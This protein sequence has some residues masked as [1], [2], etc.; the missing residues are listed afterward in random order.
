MKSN[1]FFRAILLLIAA[2]VP[3]PITYAWSELGHRV[4]ARA[5]QEQLSSNAQIRLG[6]LLGKTTQ[7][8]DVATWADEIIQERPETESWHSI[9]IPPNASKV[10]L[11][12]DCPLGECITAKVRDCIGIVRLSVKPKSQIIESFKMLVNLAADMHHPLRN[13]YPPADSKDMNVVVLGNEEMS[14][15]DAWEDALLKHMGSEDEILS[16]VQLRIQNADHEKWTQGNLRAWTW[17]TH[18][19]AVQSIYPMVSNETRTVLR[20]ASLEESSRII[21]EQLAKSAVR[22]A[23]LL[24]QAWP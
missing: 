4:V 13:G 18:N 22:L 11:E 3:I 20:A 23:F 7:L 6:Y 14:L 5:A 9:T 21:E 8:V 17:E 15:F 10:V 19:I 2:T 1:L 24:D 16:R 12:R